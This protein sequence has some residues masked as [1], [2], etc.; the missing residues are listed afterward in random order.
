M[1]GAVAGLG[2]SLHTLFHVVAVWAASSLIKGSSSSWAACVWC[3]YSWRTQRQCHC[4]WQQPT[5]TFWWQCNLHGIAP[6]SIFMFR[7]I[8]LNGC[9]NITLVNINTNSLAIKAGACGVCVW[10]SHYGNIVHI[11]PIYFYIAHGQTDRVNLLNIYTHTSGYNCIFALLPHWPEFPQNEPAES[12]I[13]SD[14]D[15]AI[16]LSPSLSLSLFRS[17]AQFRRQSIYFLI[18]NSKI[19]DNFEKADMCLWFHNAM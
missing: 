14:C 2:D 15:F 18:F 1:F 8:Y 6:I 9:V 4:R 5:M 3:D 16:S 12:E 17:S 7:Y 19:E 11:A 13:L 10:L